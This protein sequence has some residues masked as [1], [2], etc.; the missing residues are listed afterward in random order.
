MAIYFPNSE[1]G[2][3]G[4]ETWRIPSSFQGDNNIIGG[5]SPALT[6]WEKADDVYGG[7]NIPTPILTHSNGQFTFGADYYGWYLVNF[8]IYM[9]HNDN[10]RYGEMALYVSWNSGAN[11]DIHAYATASTSPNTSEN[12]NQCASGSSMVNATS[13]TRLRFGVDNRAGAAYVYGS[14]NAT[15]TGFSIIRIADSP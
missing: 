9:Y 4:G 6:N 1:L 2:E 10:N 3:V 11:W 12:Y 5:Q 14:T 15:G 8:Q 7:G 13:A